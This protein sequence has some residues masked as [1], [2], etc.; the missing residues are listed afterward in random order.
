MTRSLDE[1]LPQLGQTSQP[2]A[3]AMELCSFLIAPIC[4]IYKVNRPDTFL[5]RSLLRRYQ[6]LPMLCP[7]GIKRDAVEARRLQQQCCST[8]RLS[9]LHFSSPLLSSAPLS[10]LLSTSRRGLNPRVSTSRPTRAAST[11]IPS[12]LAVFPSLTSKRPREPVGS[13]LSWLSD[14][15]TS[16]SSLQEP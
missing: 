1:R 6:T 5:R 10:G 13:I 8:S 14:V 2:H 12:F 16:H 7:S 4:H 15:L 9:H 11:G 3:H